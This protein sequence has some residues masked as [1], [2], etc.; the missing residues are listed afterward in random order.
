MSKEIPLGEV[1]LP[2]E[3]CLK[4]SENSCRHMNVRKPGDPAISRVWKGRRR[5]LFTNWEGKAVRPAD[6][7]VTEKL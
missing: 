5:E 4:P 3:E 1:A 2:K 7:V 6:I